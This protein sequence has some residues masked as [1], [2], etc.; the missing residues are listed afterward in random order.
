MPNWRYIDSLLQLS[1][2]FQS[3]PFSHPVLIFDIMDDPKMFLDL[4]VNGVLVSQ[5]SFVRPK[6]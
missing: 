5:C 6:L 4:R 2:P 1:L 3:D